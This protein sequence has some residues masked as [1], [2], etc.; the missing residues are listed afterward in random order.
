[1]REIGEKH[2]LNLRSMR[3]KTQLKVWLQFYYPIFFLF[4]KDLIKK[5]ISFD[6]YHDK[7]DFSG[8][9]CLQQSI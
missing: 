6:D 2:I 5:K 4:K 9:I 7:N 8:F 1:M 3:S